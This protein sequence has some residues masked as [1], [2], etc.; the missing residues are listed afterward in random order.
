MKY[1]SLSQP[2]S[3]PPSLLLIR[4]F[5]AKWNRR[6]NCIFRSIQETH[7]SI[8]I[9]WLKKIHWNADSMQ[10]AFI[11]SNDAS[12]SAARVVTTKALFTFFYHSFSRA[13]ESNALTDSRYSQLQLY[14]M[15]LYLYYVDMNW[16]VMKLS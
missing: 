12:T 3:L 4:S 8:G 1:K 2:P 5:D 13:L 10:T 16:T 15:H 14:R 7:E 11:V 6:K 9:N